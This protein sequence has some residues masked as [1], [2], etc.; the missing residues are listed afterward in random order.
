[1]QHTVS[2]RMHDR[3]KTVY[4]ITLLSIFETINKLLDTHLVPNAVTRLISRQRNLINQVASSLKNAKSVTQKNSVAA[5][6][7]PLLQNCQ[8]E[9]SHAVKNYGSDIQIIGKGVQE[10]YYVYI[11][12]SN[13]DF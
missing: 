10:G 13:K 1:M 9:L 4:S 12:F 8:I 7:K 11:I 2:Y 5:W 6:G 3:H